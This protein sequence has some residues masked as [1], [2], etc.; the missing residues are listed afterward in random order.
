[1]SPRKH[2]SGPTRRRRSLSS[3]SA[4]VLLAAVC[5]PAMAVS[6]KG[7]PKAPTRP[8]V[9][10]QAIKPTIPTADRHAPGKVFLEHADMLNMDQN[11]SGGEY[12]LLRGNVVFR[13]GDMYMYCDSAH[14]YDK[15]NSLD[16]FSNVRME[17]GDTLFVYGDELNYNGPDEFATLYG[18]PGVPVRL[19]NRDVKLVTDIFYYDLGQNYGFYDVGGVLTDKQNRLES[20]R[21]E[22]YPDSKNADFYD[23]VE[24][25][26]LREGGDTLLM[27]TDV[28]NYNTNTHIARISAPTRIINRDG[29]ILSSSGVYNTNNGVGD[30]YNRS[31]VIS[32]K[33]NTLTADTLFYDRTVG[34]GEGWGNVVLVDSA[35]ESSLHGAYGF[36]DELRDSAFVTGRALAKQYR[37]GSDTLYLHG[38]TINAFMTLPDSIRFT[39]AFHGV[40]FYRTDMQGICDSMSICDVDSMMRMFYSPVVWNGDKQIFGNIIEVHIN[41]STAD[42]AHLPDFGLMSQHILEDCFDQLSGNKMTAWFNDSVITR[43]YVE[44]NV[45][46]IMFPMESDSAYN[47]YAFTESSF[48]DAYFKDGQVDTIKMWPETSGRVVP[49]YLAKKGSYF[50]P[51]FKWMETLRPTSP[52]SVFEP[53]RDPEGFLKPID[54]GQ[55]VDI[56]KYDPRRR[57]DDEEEPAP[58]E[59]TPTP[60][61]GAP[62]SADGAPLPADGNLQTKLRT[63]PPKP[64]GDPA[65]DSPVPAD[66]APAD[67]SPAPA[68]VTPD[69][70]A[71]EAGGTADGEIPAEAVGEIRPVN[72]ETESDE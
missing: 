27:Y 63:L 61:E 51:R 29:T 47:K 30:L 31:T 62:S 36:Y 42:R 41:D 44:G 66:S 56:S 25:R 55:S 43:L 39:N 4:I 53:T 57:H 58:A 45:Q 34:K 6:Q 32:K 2:S 9:A 7:K 49:L 38:D 1:M 19:I 72:Q 52:G 65:A 26:S 12:Q 5:V 23:N 50:L 28:L 11:A 33:G 70:E 68:D 67:A 14:F 17:Q 21:G 64:A 35:N 22:Y 71:T 40:R 54:T 24:L 37:G 13:K 18:R 60:A 3:W 15:T 59:N 16:A 8:A 69:A 46:T 10:A 48:M 20:L